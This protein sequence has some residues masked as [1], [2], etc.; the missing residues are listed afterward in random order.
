MAFVR[1]PHAKKMLIIYYLLM[2][3]TADSVCVSQY[4]QLQRTLDH[5]TTKTKH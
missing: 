1:G 5:T 3:F 2:S 4:L